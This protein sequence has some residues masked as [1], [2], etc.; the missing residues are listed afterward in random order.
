MTEMT[1]IS[2]YRNLSAEEI[3][4]INEIKAE[5]IR[6]KDLIDRVKN[7][8]GAD[9]RWTAIGT[10]DLQTGFMALVRAIARPTGF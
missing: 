1:D 7:S 10:T 4:I 6:M 3:A 8:P 5:G 9:P 2:G